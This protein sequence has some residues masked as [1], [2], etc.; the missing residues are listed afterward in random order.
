MPQTNPFFVLAKSILEIRSNG[1]L[2][3]IIWGS[4]L[5]MFP[6]CTS[7][8]ASKNDPTITKKDSVRLL[9][10][11]SK[12]RGISKPFKTSKL[13]QAYEQASAVNNDSL[14]CKYYSEISL[15]LSSSSI[16]SALF[17]KVNNAAIRL[18][19]Q[20][21]DSVCLSNLHWDLGDFMN[22]NLV[23]D[24]A[25]YH[26]SLAE[27]L[28]SAIKDEASAGGVLISI[29][30]LQNSIG[31]YTGGEITAIKGLEKL[32]PLKKYRQIYECYNTLADISKL[33]QEYDRALEYYDEALSYMNKAGMK[34]NRKQRKKNDIA[35]VYQKMGQH[36]KAITMFQDVLSIDSLQLKNPILYAKTLNNLGRSYRI[37]NNSQKLPGLFEAAFAIQD[38]INDIAGKAS[39][40][41][42]LANY[43]LAIKDS[44]SALTYL[45]KSKAF[46]QQSSDNKKLLEVLSLFPRVDPSNGARYA[47]AYIKLN[48]S[49][50]LEE[51]KI[52][53]KFTR[54]QFET[55]EVSAENE[56]LT[57]Q[58]QLWTG[59][60][61]ILLLL[62]LA[63][64]IIVTQRNRNQKLKFEE[65]QQKSNQEIFN[66]LLAQNE[67]VE[68]GKK[69][70]QKRVSEELHDGV[71]GR[72]LG[73]R[74][75]LLGLNKKT[76]PEAVSQR[77]KAIRILQDIETEVRSISHELSHSAYQKIHNFILSIQELLDTIE[78]ASQ[79]EIILRYTDA[80][81]YDALNGDIKINLYRIIQ[82]SIQN[83]VKHAACSK[84]QVNFE[85]DSEIL[86]VVIID[87]GKGFKVKKSKKGIGM[88]NIASRMKKVNGTFNIESAL[89]SGTEIILEIPIIAIEDSTSI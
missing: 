35:L 20:T 61:A 23:R 42:E 13:N 71:L 29:A 74:M 47:E 50:Q 7:K 32:K 44:V 26:Y 18:S 67:K 88:R 6:S 41:F 58:K 89:G 17:R 72:M 87:D 2:I 33:L 66:L 22:T 86:K 65:Q 55:D 28:F 75:M 70:E 46:A 1:W 11:Q 79:I 15:A 85:A 9:I 49:L 63:T 57:R 5:L 16:D 73:T 43:Y 64:Y 60:A 45:E 37:S 76:D 14:K 81:D 68:E 59:I 12:A 48:D 21:K 40:S 82:E 62:T 36:Q 53:G 56:L 69:L 4:V 27:K 34:H 38:S 31:D 54:I 25:Y 19:E 39:S 3:A 24:S 30:R 8:G 80:I 83:A 52:R 77:A 10:R 78:A 51:R 84:I